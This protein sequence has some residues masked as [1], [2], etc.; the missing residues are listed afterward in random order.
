MRIDMPNVFNTLL[1]SIQMK[2][3]RNG[4]AS[5][6]DKEKHMLITQRIVRR[7]VGPVTEPEK[8]REECQMNKRC[9]GFGGSWNKGDD[10]DEGPTWPKE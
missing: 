4:L 8:K 2:A 3:Y 6:T 5:L 10:E 1:L 7:G 9:L